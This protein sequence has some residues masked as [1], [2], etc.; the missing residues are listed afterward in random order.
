MPTYEETVPIVDSSDKS[1]LNPAAEDKAISEDKVTRQDL[2][3]IDQNNIIDGGRTRGVQ[4][5]AYAQEKAVDAQVDSAE[6]EESGRSN[7]QNL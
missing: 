1:G 6:V 3:D 5:D 7:M 2:V 4:N